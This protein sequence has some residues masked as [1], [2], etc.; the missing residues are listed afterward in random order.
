MTRS[1]NGLSK[2]YLYTSVILSEAKNLDVR[3]F[4]SLRVTMHES[5]LLS[6]IIESICKVYFLTVPKLRVMLR[7]IER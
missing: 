4:A 5:A 2:N 1:T 7:R 6:R 3:P